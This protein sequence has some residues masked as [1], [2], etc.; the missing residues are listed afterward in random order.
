[1]PF[2]KRWLMFDQDDCP[3]VSQSSKPARGCCLTVS[4]QGVAVWNT[5]E[6]S[7]ILSLSIEVLKN[8]SNSWLFLSPQSSDFHGDHLWSTFLSFGSPHPGFIL[9]ASFSGAESPQADG[10]CIFLFLVN[11]W[12]LAI[13]WSISP[14][15]MKERVV[16][17]VNQFW[18]QSGFWNQII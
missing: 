6:W 12:K 18:K 14:E 9:N 8:Q 1:M 15:E 2:Q 5:Y 16:F 11:P 4:L 17:L 7:Q 13:L 3:L 10:S